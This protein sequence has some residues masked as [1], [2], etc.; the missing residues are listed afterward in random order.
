MRWLL[1]LL[2]V[3]PSL[4]FG[5]VN[6]EAMRS[7][8]TEDGVSGS[9][10][11]SVAYTGGNI[12]F[13]D[14][15]ASAHLELMKEKNLV[16]VVMNY[17]FAAKRTQA[18]LLAEPDIGLWDEEAHFSNNRLAHLRYNRTLADGFWWEAYTQYEYNEFLLL[19][20]RLL[21]GTGPRFRVFDLEAAGLWFGISAMIEE[22]RLNEERVAPS[23][24]VSRLNGRASSYASLTARLTENASWTSTVYA[25][26]RLDAFEDYRVVVESGLSFGVGKALAVTIDGRYRTDSQPPKTPSGAAPILSSDFSIKN[27]LKLSF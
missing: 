11:L 18:D 17:R 8:G 22:E 23:E 7:N 4:A 13:A 6:V 10:A 3:M 14:F 21:V 12:Q 19:D 1:V 5:Q 16:F 25:Q 20:R 15:G 27:G 9:T 24:E 2:M 26:P